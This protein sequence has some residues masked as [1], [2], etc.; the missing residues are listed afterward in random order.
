MSAT[1]VATRI[2]ELDSSFHEIVAGEF[3]AADG[4]YLNTG[5]CGRKPQSVLSAIAGGWQRLNANP[6]IMTFLDDEPI[7]SARNTAARLFDI[8][9]RSLL[10]TQNSTQGLQF[11]LFNLLGKDDEFVTTDREHGCVNAISRYLEETRGVVTRRYPIDAFEGSK[12]FCD[13]ILNLVT[14]KTKVVLVSQI[15]SYNTWRPDLKPLQ[16]ALAGSGVELI[17]DGAHAPGQGV[18]RPSDFRIWVGSGHKWLGGPN[19]TGFVVLPPDL[20]PKLQPLLLG[21]QHYAKKDADINDATRFESVGTADVVR[22]SGLREAC[23]LLMRIDPAR[24]GKKQLLMAEYYRRAVESL[25]PIFR[26]PDLFKE[27]PEEASGMVVCHWPP[28]RLKVTDIKQT[29]WDRFRIWVQPDFANVNPGLGLRVSCHYATSR[30][31]LDKLVESLSQ[32]IS[33]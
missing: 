13:G 24:V 30:G 15:G 20:V 6:T 1:T 19:G 26:T 32:L 5:S 29:L 21:D 2:D 10:F 28:E 31:D 16:E 22:W 18:C 33:N 17:V 27:K 7:T 11:L 9:P 4:L 12:K 23:E 14:A 3:P 8:A 25:N